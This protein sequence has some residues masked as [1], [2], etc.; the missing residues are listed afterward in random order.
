MDVTVLKT[1][2]SLAMEELLRAAD[3]R[4]SWRQ[5]EF[6][7]PLDSNEERPPAMLYTFLP[8]VYVLQPS[9]DIPLSAPSSPTATV[10]P[11]GSAAPLS[12]V[13]TAGATSTTAPSD[14][15]QHDVNDGEVRLLLHGDNTFEYFWNLKRSGLRAMEHY[16]EMTGLWSKPVLNRT[17]RGDEDQRVFLTVKKMRFQRFSNYDAE[18]GCWKLALKTLTRHGSD[19]ASVGET[20]RGI[21]PITLVFQCSADG[22]A[23]ESTGAVTPAQL[24]SNSPSCRVLAGL[25][26]KVAN[27]LGA[28]IDVMTDKWLPQRSVRLVRSTAAEGNHVKAF[29]PFFC[30]AQALQKQ[31]VA[32]DLHPEQ[33]PLSTA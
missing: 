2:V 24:L 27:K 17:R 26:K 20:E 11:T 12:A 5:P 7:P 3:S 19:W 15:H 8:G 4:V 1:H 21:P 16:V 29:N 9:T 6:A 18:Q 31:R 30:L 13:S 22:L 10:A 33:E 32:K 14:Q 28:P 23:L 25:T